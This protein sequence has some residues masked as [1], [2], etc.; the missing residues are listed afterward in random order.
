VSARHTE[1]RLEAMSADGTGDNE[2]GPYFLQ[3]DDRN[4][5]VTACN[6]SEADARRLAACWNVCEGIP[7]DKIEGKTLAEYVANEAYLTGMEPT[8]SGM[9]IGLKGIGVQLMV[10]SLAGQ[11][12]GS[13]AVNFLE[14]SLSHEET[15]PMLV[16]L[17]R[18]HG[19]TPA[20]Q[21]AAA[22]R[23]LDEARADIRAVEANYEAARAL[24]REI[25]GDTMSVLAFGMHERIRA[26]LDG[27]GR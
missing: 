13:G 19:E 1:G 2:I 9:H 27:E 6:L 16:T 8:E 21:K 15:G 23:E 24:L 20:Q 10:E 11:F 14:V 22:L 3:G 7:T 12:K 5:V 18:L 26:F 25:A 4:E 17:Q